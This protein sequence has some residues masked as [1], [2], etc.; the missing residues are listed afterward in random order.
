[1]IARAERLTRPVPLIPMCDSLLIG[2]R[3][4]T[5]WVTIRYKNGLR[6]VAIWWQFMKNIWLKSQKLMTYDIKV[7]IFVLLSDDYEI[8]K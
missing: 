1:M 6:F 7:V 2:W 4:V 8:L 5:N 3:F